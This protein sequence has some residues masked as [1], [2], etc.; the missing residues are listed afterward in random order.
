MV[1]E[2]YNVSGIG[3][4]FWSMKNLVHLDLSSNSLRGELPHDFGNMTSLKLLELS[5]NSLSGQ[6]PN[7]IGGSFLHYLYAP[8]NNINGPI[9]PFF[10]AFNSSLIVVDLSHNQITRFI[11]SQ[12]VG[13]HLQSLRLLD[14]AN[15]NLHGSIP[16][17]IGELKALEV[18]DLSHNKLGG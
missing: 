7:N 10:A 4:D 6:I 9:P 5:N 1:F 12:I 14:L 13:S 16:P 11:P 17:W 2:C 3:H 15:N 8:F 18:L